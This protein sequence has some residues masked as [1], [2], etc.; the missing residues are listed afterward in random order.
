MKKCSRCGEMKKADDFYVRGNGRLTS[1]C[2]PCHIKATDEYRSRDPQRWKAYQKQYRSER[3]E[4]MVKYS[5]A[6]KLRHPDRVR[7]QWY[8]TNYGIGL[9]QYEAMLADQGGRCAACQEVPPS[10]AKKASQRMLNV[11]HDHETGEVRGLL[12]SRCNRILGFA[13]DRPA[14]LLALVAYLDG[15]PGWSTIRVEAS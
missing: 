1:W 8:R 9:A 2:R 7:D 10:D 14:V 4:Q 5:Q 15:G 6:Y 3:R 13:E 11:D 12:C